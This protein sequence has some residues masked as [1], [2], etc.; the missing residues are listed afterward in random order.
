MSYNDNVK[1]AGDTIRVVIH[2]EQAYDVLDELAS[3]PRIDTLSDTLAKLS[4]L[5]TKVI[6]DLKNKLDKIDNEECK[7][8]INS[9]VNNLQ[10][11]FKR[12]DE[13]YNYIKSLQDEKKI[14]AELKRFAAY[15]L[16]PD[17]M[18]IRVAECIEQYG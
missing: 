17:P 11:W 9:A 16:A 5:T 12:Q 1:D 7:K 15:A 2:L 6:N 18:S 8:A 10:W 3:N 4:R 14:R 13:L